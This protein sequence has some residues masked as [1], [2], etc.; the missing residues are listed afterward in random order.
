MSSEG[1]TGDDIRGTYSVSE[2]AQVMDDLSE[3]AQTVV[4]ELYWGD[5]HQNEYDLQ[6]HTGL[7]AED[8]IDAITILEDNGLVRSRPD[9]ASDE[10]RV[11]WMNVEDD[12]L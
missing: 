12:L 1:Y 5:S 3:N 9:F 6:Q 10:N 8:I 11:Y 4:Q 7:E 2:A